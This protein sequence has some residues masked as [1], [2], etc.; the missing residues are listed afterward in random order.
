MNKNILSLDDLSKK[1][2]ENLITEAIKFKKKEITGKSVL[3]N[4]N[5][6]LIFQQPSTRTRV[7]FYSAIHQLE[8]NSIELDWESLQISRGESLESVIKSLSCYLDGLIIRWTEHKHLL[9][10]CQ[11]SS[12]PIINAL[13]ELYHP[14][15]ILAD[16]MT[17]YETKSDLTRIELAFIGDANNNIARTLLQASEIFSFKLHFFSPLKPSY[18][19]EIKFHNN[20]EMLDI[21]PQLDYIYTDVRQSLGKDM[22]NNEEKLKDYQV[23]K[24]LLNFCKKKIKVMHC[25]PAHIGEEISDEVFSSSDT[26]I[27]Q[28]A[29][30]RLHIQKALINYLF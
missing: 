22:I 26:L 10:I 12:I 18:K 15:Q 28:Q 4:K 14:C 27:W 25:L 29:E 17:I 13:T 3:K 1:E 16:L 21:C 7:S 20:K 9:E 2:I 30:N 24:E 6:G 19:K 11:Y 23:N 5:F 8:G